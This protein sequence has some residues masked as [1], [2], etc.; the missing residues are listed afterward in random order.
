MSKTITYHAFNL[1]KVTMVP[2]IASF[3]TDGNI[4]PLY[5]RIHGNSLKVQS[6]RIHHV[7]PNIIEFHCRVI[8]YNRLKPLILSYYQ[9]EKIWVIPK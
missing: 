8:D 3:D 4:L 7:S 5:V 9:S 6:S 1:E 2:V